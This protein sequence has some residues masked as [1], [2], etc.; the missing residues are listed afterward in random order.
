MAAFRRVRGE[1]G[2]SAVEFSLIAPLMV[3]L[4]MG[5]VDVGRALYVQVGLQDAVQEGAVVGSYDPGDPDAIR[6]RAAESSDYPPLTASNVTVTCPSG[7]IQVAARYELKLITP[8]PFFGGSL[9]IASSN[10]GQILGPGSCV[11]S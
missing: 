2:V 3:L 6:A 5:I 7:G 1:R 11:P 9:T 4:F 8:L 10:V